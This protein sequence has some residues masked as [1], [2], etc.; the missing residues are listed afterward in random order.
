MQRIGA[1]RATLFSGL[2]PVAAAGTAPLVGT[3]SY[4]LAQAAGSALVGLG[5]ALGARG[6]GPGLG[7]QARWRAS[8][9]NDPPTT[10][11]GNGRPQRRGVRAPERPE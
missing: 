8:P 10:F 9:P 4:G 11:R 2:I 7:G 5:V 1:E 3:G 6:A